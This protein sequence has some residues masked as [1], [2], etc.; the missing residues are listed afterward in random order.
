MTGSTS[1][2]QSHLPWR[3]RLIGIAIVLMGGWFLIAHT[4]SWVVYGQQLNFLS[5]SY[6]ILGGVLHVAC[7]IGVLRHRKWAWFLSIVLMVRLLP[8]T[9]K[10]WYVFVYRLLQPGGVFTWYV[11]LINGLILLPLIIV[12][13]YT[14]WILTRPGVRARFIHENQ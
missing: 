14:F 4:I 7:G 13:L 3:I 1:L 12:P 10:T 2:E 6:Q 8:Y 11:E 5:R 9:Y